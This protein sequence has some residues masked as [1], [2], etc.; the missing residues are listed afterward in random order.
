[1]I[2]I[3]LLASDEA[4]ARAKAAGFTEQTVLIRHNG[5]QSTEENKRKLEREIAHQIRPYQYL[6]SDYWGASA[7]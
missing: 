6:V 4:K 1:M 5:C 7:E 2:Q 3:I